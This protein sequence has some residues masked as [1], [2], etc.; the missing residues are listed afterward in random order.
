MKP[1]LLPHLCNP[2]RRSFSSSF[3]LKRFVSFL[4]FATFIR[5]CGGFTIFH[6]LFSAS[7]LSRWVSSPI[8]TTSDKND[9]KF[10][11]AEKKTKKLSLQIEIFFLSSASRKSFCGWLERILCLCLS[12][13]YPSQFRIWIQHLCLQCFRQKLLFSSIQWAKEMKRKKRSDG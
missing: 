9:A 11:T 10:A 2:P 3:K 1:F 8:P 13:N 6:Q 7:S 12:R 4:A 5:F